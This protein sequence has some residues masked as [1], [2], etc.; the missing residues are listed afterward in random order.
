M[1]TVI[2]LLWDIRQV[3]EF[4]THGEPGHLMLL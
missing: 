1:G 3:I 2:D 4:R